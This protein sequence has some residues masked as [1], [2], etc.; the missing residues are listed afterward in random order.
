[1]A[2]TRLVSRP[3]TLGDTTGLRVSAGIVIL[4][5]LAILAAV[6]YRVRDGDNPTWMLAGLGIGGLVLPVAAVGAVLE[7]RRPDRHLRWG[8][9]LL[10]GMLVLMFMILG[11]GALLDTPGSVSTGSARGPETHGQSR[12]LGVV[13]LIVAAVIAGVGAIGWRSRRQPDSE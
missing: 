4:L 10:L 13:L 12:V 6:L 1:V 2:G 7:S 5:G 9:P 11:L 3:S 8:G